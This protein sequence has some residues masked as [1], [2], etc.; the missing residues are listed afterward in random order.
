MSSDTVEAQIARAWD[1]QR[2]GQAADAAKE[3]ERIL[4]QN[5]DNI[6]AH[7]GMGLA[8]RS[9]GQNAD[10]LEHFQQALK[11]VE[12]AAET[13]RP[14]RE[15]AERNEPNTTEDDRYMMLNRMIKQ[16]L[17]EINAS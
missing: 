10:A 13:R 8:K 1:F 14:A 12:A 3:F 17:A 6:D 7:Y 16:R 15:G 2:K 5:N 9:S 11:L 4:K